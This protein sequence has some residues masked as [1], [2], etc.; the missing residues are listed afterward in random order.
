MSVQP[1]AAVTLIKSE[2]HCLVVAS[3]RLTVPTLGPIQANPL[4]QRRAKR[5][6]SP[7]SDLN[8]CSGVDETQSPGVISHAEAA[9]KSL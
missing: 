6:Q 8:S 5:F 7:I 3:Q 2:K 1:T 4:L 9:D